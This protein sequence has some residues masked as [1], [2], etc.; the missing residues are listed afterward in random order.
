M[1]CSKARKLISPY[2]DSELSE[3]N[4]RELESH[5]SVCESC[6]SEMRELLLKRTTNITTKK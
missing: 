5:V 2:V 6:R 3:A 1:K 4:K